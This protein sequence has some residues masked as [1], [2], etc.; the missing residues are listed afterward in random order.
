M[1]LAVSS[2]DGRASAALNNPPCHEI[3]TM[4]LGGYY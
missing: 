3:V 2:S 1:T 4:M